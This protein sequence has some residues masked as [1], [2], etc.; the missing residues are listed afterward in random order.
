MNYVDFTSKYLCIDKYDFYLIMSIIIESFSSICLY[1]SKK[2]YKY[3]LLSVLGYITS[4]SM[5]PIALE[6]YKLCVAYTLW[7]GCGIIF[8]TFYD[9]IQNSVSLSYQRILGYIIII[10]GMIIT[11]Y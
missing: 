7:C 9:T 1:N 5:F 4:F 2:N 3:L 10:I 8:T 11:T 6:K